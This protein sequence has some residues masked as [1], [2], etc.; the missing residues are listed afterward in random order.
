MSRVVLR[1]FDWIIIGTVVALL[2]FL[3]GHNFP[4]AY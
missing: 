3:I 2:I 1:V 4:I